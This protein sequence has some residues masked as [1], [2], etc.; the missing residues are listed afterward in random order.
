[1]IKERNKLVEKYE[2]EISSLNNKISNLKSRLKSLTNSRNNDSLKNQL[3]GGESKR[4]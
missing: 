2:S 3:N 1:M 4:Q